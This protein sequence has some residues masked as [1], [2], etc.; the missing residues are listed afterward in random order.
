MLS[1]L[2]IVP[3][4]NFSSLMRQDLYQFAYVICV[5]WNWFLPQNSNDK[6]FMNPCQKSK[7]LLDGM[8]CCS[9]YSFYFS[10]FPCGI[11]EKRK[12]FS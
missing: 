11:V 4:Q 5:S 2:T 10:T 3:E 7:G 12:T 1:P 8:V 9:A 6:A